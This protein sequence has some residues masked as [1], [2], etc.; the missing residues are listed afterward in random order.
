MLETNGTVVEVDREF[1]W[2][3]TRPRSA[4]SSCGTGGCTTSVLARLFGARPSRLR[5]QNSLQARVGQQVVVGIPD[6]VLVN[7]SVLAY[8]VPLLAMLFAGTVAAWT[9]LGELAQV[10]MILSGLLAG[11]ALVGRITGS[12]RS[13]ARYAPRLLRVALPVDVG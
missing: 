6:S 12:Q 9:G 10:A 2:V 8:L 5:L 1:I 4:C 3:E 11:I 13:R 7:A